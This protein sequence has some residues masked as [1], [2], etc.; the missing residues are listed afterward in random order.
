MLRC[1][2]LELSFV[3][4]VPALTTLLSVHPFAM[5]GYGN[6]QHI[7]FRCRHSIV[8]RWQSRSLKFSLLLCEK[9]AFSACWDASCSFSLLFFCFFPSD[10]DCPF[11]LRLHVR[12]CQQNC[13]AKR[14]NGFLRGW[15]EHLDYLETVE[16]CFQF[17]P[18]SVLQRKTSNT[19]FSLIF[20][21]LSVCYLQFQT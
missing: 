5:S 4:F 6:Q 13:R 15:T 8:P 12:K 1:M 3:V 9:R 16:F 18:C 7:V 14:G 10:L 2:C 11:V 21:V 20:V 19:R 17:K